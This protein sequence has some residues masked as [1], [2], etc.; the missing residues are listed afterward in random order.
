M[1]TKPPTRV[2]P[3]SLLSIF[4]G[5][6]FKKVNLTSRTA[7][8]KVS[9]RSRENHWRVEKTVHHVLTQRGP[10]HQLGAG[11]HPLVLTGNSPRNMGLSSERKMGVPQARTRRIVDT[12]KSQKWMMLFRGSPMTQETSISKFGISLDQGHF[13]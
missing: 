6:L 10:G 7:P 5:I 3:N 9:L 2:A 1:A 12:G 13:Q 8:K 4:W 11:K